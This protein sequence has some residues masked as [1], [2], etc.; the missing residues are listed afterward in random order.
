MKKW[1]TI[2]GNEKFTTREIMGWLWNA[3]RRYGP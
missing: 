1:F 3:W 2:T